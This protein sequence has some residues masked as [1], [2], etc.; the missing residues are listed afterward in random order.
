MAVLQFAFGGDAKNPY[1]PHNLRQNGVIYPGTHDNDT[2][3]GWY[4]LAGEPTRDHVRRYLRVS[5][6][7]IGWDLVRT[8][9]SAVSRIAVVP[10]QDLLSLG[11][12]ARLNSPGIPQGNWRWRLAEGAIE[13]LATGGTAAYLAELASLNG[14]MP[15]P[16]AEAPAS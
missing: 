4:A 13:R 2:A 12:E 7:D 16:P 10:M 3:I 8:A 5:G 6:K 1:L 9:Y 15:Q 14:R 11:S